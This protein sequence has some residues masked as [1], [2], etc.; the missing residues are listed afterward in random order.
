MGLTEFS[1]FVGQDAPKTRT[2]KIM[3][4]RRIRQLTLLSL[5]LFTV[6]QTSYQQYVPRQWQRTTSVILHP[7]AAVDDPDV[8]AYI[9]SL[10]DDDLRPMEEWFFEQA[11]SYG[12]TVQPYQ[13]QW[14]ERVES[15]PPQPPSVSNPLQAAWYSLKFRGFASTQTPATLTQWAKV[16]IYFLVHPA[17][18]AENLHSVALQRGLV[19]LVQARGSRLN[20]DQNMVILAHELLHT[21]GATDKYDMVG[22]P[23]YPDGYASPDQLPLYPQQMAEISAAQVA[24][25]PGLSKLVDSLQYAKVGK[26]TATEIGWR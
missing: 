4:F 14:G 16:H 11:R 22:N 6:A 10:N 21:V 2:N 5:L 12:L 7:I 24:I 17:D 9:D 18:S 1:G 23:V 20:H 26:L 25:R 15:M 19:A 13:F 8:Q 3:S